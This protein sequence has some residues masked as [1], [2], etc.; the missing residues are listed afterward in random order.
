[1]IVVRFWFCCNIILSDSVFHLFSLLSFTRFCFYALFRIL[2]HFS[3]FI[4]TN[5]TVQIFNPIC[6]A[7]SVVIVCVCV[8]VGS[9][10]SHSSSKCAI[11]N[12]CECVR[13][14]YVIY[15]TYGAFY[16]ANTHQAIQF[17]LMF[18]DVSAN[19]MYVCVCV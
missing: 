7:W 4:I 11:I 13:F 14:V 17:I 16:T 12:V 19:C 15:I 1:M 5:Y 6:I 9:I 18:E 3:Y 2:P 10:S 8:C